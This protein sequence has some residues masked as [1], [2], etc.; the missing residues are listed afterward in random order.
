MCGVKTILSSFQDG[1][2]TLEKAEEMLNDI[3][4][5]AKRTVDNEKDKT[6]TDS[7]LNKYEGIDFYNIQDGKVVSIYWFW[8]TGD[9]TIKPARCE[10]I[11]CDIKK[12]ELDELMKD[13]NAYS[14]WQERRKHFISDLSVEEAE[15]WIQEA[16]KDK[17]A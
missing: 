17:I 7:L 4:S 8:D 13:E 15:C 6:D 16:L 2:L 1:K 10:Q 14:C 3:I 12:E 5:E 9:D 11:S